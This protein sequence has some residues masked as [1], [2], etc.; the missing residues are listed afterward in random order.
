MASSHDFFLHGDHAEGRQ[1]IASTL[2][3]QGFE[4]TPAPNNSLLAK[5]GSATLTA[6]FGVLA[7]SKFQ[8][9]FSIDFMVDNAGRLVARINRN[10]ASGALKGGAVGA[11]KTNRA[12][13]TTSNAL[14][15][16]LSASGIL[17]NALSN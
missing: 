11:S 14:A 15:S 10:M 2:T 6:L 13:E 8:I 12:F 17:A 16:A 1:I 3:A 7:G 4:V 9:T 5:R